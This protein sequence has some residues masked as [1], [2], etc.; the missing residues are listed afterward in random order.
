[1]KLTEAYPAIE[2]LG[3]NDL[4]PPGGT[5]FAENVVSRG[6]M[7]RRA[8]A[9][10][11]IG[12]FSREPVTW[13]GNNSSGLGFGLIRLPDPALSALMRDPIS[14]VTNADSANLISERFRHSSRTYPGSDGSLR[15]QRPGGAKEIHL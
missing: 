13:V 3:V 9:I 15:V 4:P 2:T 7:A 10:G 5:P 6:T 12:S 14:Q 11:W 1:M 8:S